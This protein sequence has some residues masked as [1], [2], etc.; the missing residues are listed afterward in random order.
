MMAMNKTLRNIL[1]LWVVF[2]SASFAHASEK[3]E[4]SIIRV[5]SYVQRPDFDSPWTTKQSEKLV[6]MGL[7]VEG[8]KVLVSA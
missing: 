7:I 8:N 3:L 5:I 2:F 1:L 4:A 6:H